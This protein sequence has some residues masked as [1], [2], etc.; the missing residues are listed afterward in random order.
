MPGSR[1]DGN[2]DALR[3]AVAAEPASPAPLQV[4][5]S[6]EVDFNLEPI[7]IVGTGLA[8]YHL[9]KELRKLDQKTPLIMISADDGAHYSKPQLSTAFH[10]QRSP[11]QLVSNSARVSS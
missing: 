3:T 10:K 1:G 5:A 6:S 9:A 4:A 11:E 2:G 8:G 7:V